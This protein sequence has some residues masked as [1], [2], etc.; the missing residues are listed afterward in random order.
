MLKNEIT[1]NILNEMY[2]F[3]EPEVFARL[4]NTI[5]RSLYGYQICSECR[6]VQVLENDNEK[7]L[8]KFATYLKVEQKADGTIYQY[9]NAAKD[10]LEFIHKNFRDVTAD[11]VAYYLANLEL[12]DNVCANTLDNTRKYSKSFFSWLFF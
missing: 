10:M 7:Y 6:E 3:L 12:R 4:K 8:K 5:I 9:V 2:P 11:D 1:N